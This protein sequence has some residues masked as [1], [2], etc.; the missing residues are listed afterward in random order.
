MVCNIS[1]TH[2]SIPFPKDPF[3]QSFVA[4]SDPFLFST[5]SSLS[6]LVVSTLRDSFSYD[7]VAHMLK[8]KP[9]TKKIK[10]IALATPSKFCVEHFR[11]GNPLAGLPALPTDPPEFVPGKQLTT[12]R[13]DALEVDPSGFLW[14]EEH[15]P[16][17]WLVHTHEMAFA[18]D[19]SK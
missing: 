17:L 16:I 12:D 11:V 15:K 13:A 5:S 10:P 2:S 1:E 3:D 18:W 9:V 6:L 19:A 7:S 8:Y 4:P 14:P